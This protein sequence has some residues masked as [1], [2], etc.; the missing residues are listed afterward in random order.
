M[1]RCLAFRRWEPES[2]EVEER[3][4]VPSWTLVEAARRRVEV[5]LVSCRRWPSTALVL[6]CRAILIL[7]SD[8]TCLW[9]FPAATV[10]RRCGGGSLRRSFRKVPILRSNH[11]K[12]TVM[13]LLLSC[14]VTFTRSIA[15]RFSQAS[16]L[17]RSR[18]THAERYKN[19]FTSQIRTPEMADSGIIP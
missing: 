4:W 15:F 16:A 14:S 1:E 6:L 13:A 17:G 18:R 19:R 8:R 10:E 9:V 12:A 7:G 11:R 2:K 5:G 3:P